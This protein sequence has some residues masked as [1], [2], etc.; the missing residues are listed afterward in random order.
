L[1]KIIP[2][3]A[4]SISLL[5]LLGSSHNAFAVDELPPPWRGEPN[6]IHVEWNTP[7]LTSDRFLDVQSPLCPGNPFCMFPGS[8]TSVPGGFDLYQGPTGKNPVL[9][10][11]FQCQGIGPGSCVVFLA[12]FEDNKDTKHIRIQITSDNPAAIIILG[13]FVQANVQDPDLTA[14]NCQ[15]FSIQTI[16]NTKIIDAIC[17]P[18]PFNEGLGIITGIPVAISQIIV[19][20]ISINEDNFLALEV[21][22]VSSIA[23]GSGT[24]DLFGATAEPTASGKPSGISTPF[25]FWEMKVSGLNPGATAR[26][27]VTLDSPLPT[28]AQFFKLVDLGSGLEWI[29]ATSILESNDGDNVIVLAITDGSVFDADG[30]VNGMVSDPGVIVLPDNTGE[31]GMPVGGEFIG[32]DS[33]SV[34]AAGA[35]YTAAWMIPLIVSAIGIG[36]VIAR[37]F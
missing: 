23:S 3:V 21:P 19:D 12:N 11:R 13:N 14:F 27:T 32:I 25:G 5:V 37:K 8:F 7:H 22:G 28:T 17:K 26:I 4:F 29:D 36:I 33:V 10:T 2:L 15:E 9:Q 35:Q 6:S 20:T 31:G 16:G 24:L 30:T 18:N 34:L 1:N